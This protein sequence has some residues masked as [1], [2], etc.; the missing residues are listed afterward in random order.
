M[1][2][3]GRELFAVW[4]VIFLVLNLALGVLYEINVFK[5]GI[6]GVVVSP[7][8]VYLAALILSGIPSLVRKV[9][10]R[11]TYF[12]RSLLFG[13]ILGFDLMLFSLIISEAEFLS[14][15]SEVESLLI[16]IKAAFLLIL[17]PLQAAL[18]KRAGFFFIRLFGF[19]LEKI[20]KLKIISQ[21][22]YDSVKE[23]IEAGK[24]EEKPEEVEV[25]AEKV[26]KADEAE[27]EPEKVEET[28]EKRAEAKEKKPS[29]LDGLFTA[30]G[31]FIGKNRKTL[32]ISAGALL[33]L[34]IVAGGALL[35]FNWYLKNNRA[36]ISSITPEGN[37]Y[38]R[39][40]IE[41]IYDNDI[42]FTNPDDPGEVLTIE[43][44]VK[45]RYEI[46]GRTLRFIP[47][48]AFPNSARYEVSINAGALKSP[49]KLA[50][51]SRKF[52]FNTLMTSVSNSSFYYIIDEV[53]KK[54]VE[55]VG[56]L[57][58]TLDV[59]PESLKDRV[60]VTIDGEELPFRLESSSRKSRYY[61]K[62]KGF[63]QSDEDQMIELTVLKGIK[64]VDG[65]LSSEEDH[66][67]RIALKAKEE[68]KVL[69]VE[70]HPVV[71]NTYI[72]IQFNLPV[73]E[74]NISRYIKIEPAIPFEVDAEYR[75]AVL[76]ANFQ[77]NVSYTVTVKKE[78]T[79]RYDSNMKKDY[80]RVVTVKDMEPYVRFSSSGR[81][82]PY[83]N[84]LNVEFVTLNLDDVNFKVEKVYKNN[85]VYYLT[86]QR[87]YYDDYGYGGYDD[88]YGGGGNSARKVIRN[89]T[90]TIE[91][92]NINEEVRSLVNFKELM[93]SDYEG[94]YYLTLSDTAGYY[95]YS[96]QL[97]NVTKMGLILK[98]DGTNL[99][100][101]VVDI[102]T[103]NPI[104]GVKLSLISRENQL[105]KEGLT[106]ADGSLIF[107]NYHSTKE[108][109]QPYLIFAE[110]GEDFTYLKLDQSQLDYSTFDVE[111]TSFSRGSYEAFVA[112][113]RGVYRPGE[114]V[115]TTVI[116]RSTDLSNPESVPLTVKVTDPT[117][118]E[119][120]RELFKSGA[121]GMNS[122]TIPTQS[123]FK[124]GSYALTIERYE[125][126]SIGSTSFKVEEFIPNTIEARVELVE[127]D[128][129]T[130]KFKVKANELHGAPSRGLKVKGYIVYRSRRFVHKS[131]EGY[132]FYD[133]YKEDFYQHRVELGDAKLDDN[134]EYIYSV[135]IPSTLNPPS[136][137][138]ALV[139][140]EV[141]DTA[142]RPVSDAMS[143]DLDYYSTYL[144]VK[145]E[146]KKPFIENRKLKVN[147]LAINPEG[148]RQ[149]EEY[150]TI[151]I[152]R[153]VWYT[154]F[155]K[156][157]WTESYR[158]EY[159]DELLYKKTITLDGLGSIDFTPDKGGQYTV[160]VSKEG[161]MSCSTSFYVGGRDYDYSRDMSDPYKLVMNLDKKSYT[162]GETAYLTI[163]APFDGKV[164]L[165]WERD[166]IYKTQLVELI[167]GKAIVPVQV[168]GDFVPNMYL[169]AIAYRKPT[170]EQLPLPPVS[171]G[172]VNVSLDKS[173]QAAKV[174]LST[175][176]MIRSSDGLTVELKVE[177]GA[178]T[179]VVIAAVD[180][181]ILQITSYQRP[182]PYDFFYR[183]RRLSVRT[184]TTLK[185]LLPDIAPYKK[186]FGG[187]YDGD[188]ERRHLNPIEA[189]RVKSM[190]M[191]SGIL[192]C[193]E[194]GRVSHTFKLP[195]FNGK[196]RVMVMTVKDRKFGSTQSQVT[197]SDPIVL[198][199][200]IPRF[201]SPGDKALIPVKVYNKT[202][203][204]GSFK[205]SI[206]TDGPLR[207]EGKNE[208]TLQIK[209][210]GE[211]KTIF[212]LTGENDAAV[213]HIK[214][215]GEG[216]GE[217]TFHE[218]E[219]A[220]RP[221]APLN[222]MVS[223]GEIKPGEEAI[224][225]IEGGYI[226]EGS[227]RQLFISSNK[228]VKFMGALE[229]LIRYP[230]GCSE[231]T[232]SA[233]FPLIYMKDLAKRGSL[234][235][236]NPYMID[237][238]VDIAIKKLESRQFEDGR[239]AFWDGVDYS[240]PW[241]DNY[242]SHF[243][244]EARR[245]GFP[246][247]DKA[248]RRILNKL[249][250]KEEKKGRLDRRRDNLNINRGPYE[251]YLVALAG[252]PDYDRMR[253]YYD[254]LSDEQKSKNMSETTR[255][256]LAASYALSGDK[257]KAR[258]FLP[259]S[260]K[261]NTILRTYSNEFNSYTRN[262]A[263]YLYA[264][265]LIDSNDS[266]VSFLEKELIKKITKHGHFGNTQDTA[267]ALLAINQIAKEKAESIS[268][269]LYSG[270][271]L[272]ETLTEE[273]VL[274]NDRIK[275]SSYRVVNTGS[276]T[277]YYSAVSFGVPL[278]PDLSAKTEGLKVTKKYLDINGKPIDIK[279][280]K[281]ADQIVVNLTVENKTKEELENVILVDL[282]P[283]GFEI[284]NWR[285]S[286]RGDYSNIPKHNMDIAYTDVRDDR[287]LIF[288]NKF[289]VSNTFSYVVK[290]VSPGEYKNP[291][292]LAEAMY[293]P[294]IFGRTKGGDSIVIKEEE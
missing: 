96:N 222:T 119:V 291:Q 214:L 105:L 257:E 278:Q 231:Q 135:N 83:T 6:V 189:K 113:E 4:H 27:V 284:V 279:S 53:T 14:L 272:E 45:G 72:S 219:L 181:G 246:V 80:E 75:Y 152:R 208:Y 170:Y 190:A 252:Q 38:N 287:I 292:F 52:K 216:N 156:Y 55:L 91:G 221:A 64:P 251:L 21:S 148:K 173:R 73:Y 211:A 31:S 227:Y 43:P 92:G 175:A 50:V 19:L 294:Y 87:E 277:C 76:K 47:D 256:F 235:Q 33:G 154:I 39:R 104:S 61:L 160:E 106:A 41:V 117:G 239:F 178:G 1:K 70:T 210:D 111:G 124:T 16:L 102:M 103:Q 97:I 220:V 199:P 151:Q 169:T 140:V 232:T 171:Y 8:V 193:D 99:H 253:S 69:N 116:V 100:A 134:G 25:K 183:K 108:G 29:P 188:L 122:L 203:K 249:A 63:K 133:Q 191:Y 174:D 35:G 200:G 78:L 265:S 201:M 94:L 218:T 289:Y 88:Y 127:K 77:P 123:H 146:G 125:N 58:F 141:F 48:T 209:K 205:V 217:T 65:V 22:D 121:E 40:V 89:K 242:A 37:T 168:T 3:K 79:S 138:R 129:Q 155:R 46:E 282:L 28:G 293:D 237:K 288:T 7:L 74:D 18:Y 130:L 20:F 30:I 177:N 93:K 185:D 51:E 238:Y 98:N 34:A 60:K 207:I 32:L 126:S 224:V 228:M 180:E 158:S 66:T 13:A 42:A 59:E 9:M 198:M 86:G 164:L 114:P 157:R 23:E 10:K 2:R 280:I 49:G 260:F 167:K 213:A 118:K 223:Q 274:Y 143:V 182:D 268:V 163:V 285:L 172:A 120:Y 263:L 286:S 166:R 267:W 264:M 250:L 101:Y 84:N 255:C 244:L 262:T 226:K 281:Q 131:Y 159:Y 162:P 273:T 197:I 194:N 26:E 139:Y 247:S 144:G 192:E 149:K 54:P 179:K 137:L 67:Q 240:Y 109:L 271:S 229:Y 233:A 206:K 17:V 5:E 107:N 283:A 212:Y 236:K 110:R 44:P 136:A 204:D 245:L 71:G 243:L 150:V 266:I 248:Y 12:T 258:A 57:T 82:L 187:G 270:E 85:L 145:I 147:Y 184:G 62:I 11:E 68:L 202:E 153:K 142:G 241:V 132:T 275:K 234:F 276:S 196:V 176:N 24:S 36:N 230:Y 215:Y 56:E 261:L 186:A 112:T 259:S 269:E 195:Q 115:Y 161:G 81:I 225:N 290:A 90:F 15:D 95:N 128:N 165:S 254:Q